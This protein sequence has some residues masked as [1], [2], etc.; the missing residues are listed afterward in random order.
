MKVESSTGPL[1]ISGSDL[2][3]GDHYLTVTSLS[4]TPPNSPTFIVPNQLQSFNRPHHQP[5]VGRGMGRTVDDHFLEMKLLINM[6]YLCCKLHQR[7][8]MR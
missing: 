3:S 8:S 1:H 5:V 2:V 6:H 7:T 4:T